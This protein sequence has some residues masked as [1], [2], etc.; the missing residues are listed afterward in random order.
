MKTIS[1]VYKNAI[2][3]KERRG[4]DRMYIL[5]DIHETV[6]YPTHNGNM[7]TSFYA[8]SLATLIR[9]S[10][11]PEV[12]LILWTCSSE[13]HCQQYNEIF[14]GHGIIFDYINA[15][16]EVTNTEYACF[17]KKLYAN[18]ILD[19]KAGFEPLVDWQEFYNTL[20]KIEQN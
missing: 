10:R 13:D 14:R 19:D 18:M 1:D 2:A 15:N 11:D 9:L 3:I 17:D 16:P 8:Y 5:V 4:W 6:M 7:S 20:I 12:C